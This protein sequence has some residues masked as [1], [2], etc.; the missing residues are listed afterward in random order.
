[1]KRKLIG[2][3]VV[4]V[5]L[6]LAV[7][8]NASLTELFL[9]DG[10][11][12]Y[13]TLGDKYWRKDLSQ[14]ADKTYQE[15]VNKINTFASEGDIGVWRMADLADMEILLANNTSLDIISSFF[16][17]SSD[18]WDGRFN[19]TGPTAGTHLHFSIWDHSPYG[20][21]DWT[22][23]LPWTSDAV[24]DSESRGGLGAWVVADN[25][26]GSNPNPVPEPATMILF[27]TGLAGLAAARRRKKAC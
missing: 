8:A 5:L 11:V 7:S 21:I 18:Y 25:V 27:G 3:G 13:D 24:S 17:S 19:Q 9:T 14:L 20:S 4:A 16:M 12:L 1:M 6:G 2:I 23:P 15:Q 10:F 26:S 22:S